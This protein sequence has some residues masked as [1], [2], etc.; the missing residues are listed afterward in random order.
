MKSFESS[1]RTHKP[2][3]SSEDTWTSLKIAKPSH[4]EGEHPDAGEDRS[5]VSS[6][7]TYILFSLH[8]FPSFCSL[9]LAKSF[10]WAGQTEHLGSA[11][12]A[13]QAPLCEQQMSPREVAPATIASQLPVTCKVKGAPL[14]TGTQ[15]C[16]IFRY[17]T[18]S[19]S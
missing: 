5:E 3:R 12:P 15:H 18:A 10:G 11:L 2:P 7:Q 17:F 6:N 14:L 9:L 1:Q 13:A 19:T 8:L 16:L 4:N